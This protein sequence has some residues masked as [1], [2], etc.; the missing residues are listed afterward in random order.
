[1][2]EQVYYLSLGY[3]A[4]KTEAYAQHAT[5]LLQ[6]FFLDPATRMNPNVTYGQVVRGT[7]NPSGIGR[8]EGIISTRTIAQVVNVVPA[9]Q[10]YAGYDAIAPQLVQWFQAYVEWLLSSEIGKKEFAA[11]NNHATWY[12][13]QVVIIGM[14]FGTDAQR[15]AIGRML[16][17]FMAA[18][19]PRHIDPKTGDQPLE[20]A[21]T[22][23]YHYL[24]FNLQ[25]LLYLT[26]WARAQPQ[27]VCDTQDAL[28]RKAVDYLTVYDTTKTNED[29]TE[30]VPCV[31]IMHARGVNNDAYKRLI[32]A[33]QTSANAEKITGPKH[34][35]CC[36]WS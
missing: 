27:Q 31:R 10:G 5:R 32:N 29:I 7:T 6:V 13:V 36:L 22:R 19:V 11:Q 1:M 20:S 2:A 3:I 18:D 23:P 25:A 17:Q 35:V 16:Q 14:T 26:D 15:A 24:V 33:A 4:F 8:A 28:I 30:A 12:L 9:L 21:R 34:H